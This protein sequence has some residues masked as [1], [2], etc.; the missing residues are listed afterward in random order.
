MAGQGDAGPHAGRVRPSERRCLKRSQALACSKHHHVGI[1]VSLKTL[2]RVRCGCD[3]TNRLRGHAGERARG[4][5]RLFAGLGLPRARFGLD[6]EPLSQWLHA[7]LAEA[8]L[9]VELLETRHV[10]DAF[11]GPCQSSPTRRTYAG[12]PS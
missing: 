11:R 10:R 7:T 8:G 9:A 3:G 5:D 12:S 2:E 4:A 1:D 6:A